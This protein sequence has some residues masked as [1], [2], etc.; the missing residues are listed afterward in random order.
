MQVEYTGLTGEVRFDDHGRRDYFKLDLIEKRRTNMVKTGIWYPDTGVNY[1]ATVEEQDEMVQLALQ[2][3]TLRVVTVVVRQ[4]DICILT[5]FENNGRNHVHLTIRLGFVTQY[6]WLGNFGKC[7][8]GRY[9][10]TNSSVTL[11]KVFGYVSFQL[12]C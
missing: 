1:T 4:N 7:N 2:N 8:R 10:C 5:F 11:P 3:M 9:S 6:L 12:I